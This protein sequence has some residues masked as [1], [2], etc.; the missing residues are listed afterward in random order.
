MCIRDSTYTGNVPYYL[1]N[2]VTL[3]KLFSARWADFSVKA[4]VKN[5]FDEEYVSVLG[6][7]MPGINFEIFL[8]IRPKW[9]KKRVRD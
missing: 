2:D 6:R 7:P 8:D 9:G 5:L 4:A 1:M 3:E